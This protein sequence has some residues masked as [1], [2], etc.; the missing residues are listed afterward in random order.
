MTQ[1]TEFTADM[2]KGNNI[3]WTEKAEI[4]KG[5]SKIIIH[6]FKKEPCDIWIS[7]PKT[8]NRIFENLTEQQAI[9][10]ANKLLKTL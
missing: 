1:T 4:K 8:Y 5:N 10:T 9:E 7:T 6:R 2:I 3:T